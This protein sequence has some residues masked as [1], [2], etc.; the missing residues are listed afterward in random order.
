VAPLQ[1]LP[2]PSRETPPSRLVIFL[3]RWLLFR[4][5]LE[6]G[7]VKLLSGDAMWRNLTALSVHYETQPLPTWIGWY[8]HQLPLWIQKISC[9]LMF[10]IELVASLLLFRAATIAILCR[11]SDCTAA[12]FYLAHGELHIFQLSDPGIVPVVAG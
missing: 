10:F 6:S 5:M 7:C 9:L 11:R 8:V 12:G 1:L 4:L 3:L 2:S